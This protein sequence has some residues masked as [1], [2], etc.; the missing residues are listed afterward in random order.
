MKGR[1][2]GRK[3]ERDGGREGGTEG[4]KEGQRDKGTEGGREGEGITL[5]PTHTVSTVYRKSSFLS[6]P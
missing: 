1:E 3:G 2:G 5:S 4:E 6:S